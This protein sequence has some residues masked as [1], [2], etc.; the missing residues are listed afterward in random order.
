[1]GTTR[2]NVLKYAAGNQEDN[3]CRL[4][5]AKAFKLRTIF[6]YGDDPDNDL[7]RK[8]MTLALV[9]L[10]HKLEPDCCICY[11]CI[12]QLEDFSKFQQQ[13]VEFN[14][15]LYRTRGQGEPPPLPEV[16]SDSQLQSVSSSNSVSKSGR[17]TRGKGRKDVDPFGSSQDTGSGG[18]R[19]SKAPKRYSPTVKKSA[20]GRK[21]GRKVVKPQP[22]SSLE[23][24][25]S[26]SADDYIPLAKRKLKASLTK[27]KS[28]VSPA[29]PKRSR[30]A[31]NVSI[32]QSDHEI[33]QT[34]HGRVLTSTNF[35]VYNAGHGSINIVAGGY[36]YYKYR[37]YRTGSEVRYG[38]QCIEAGCPSQLYTSSFTT[39]TI[40]WRDRFYEHN[41]P[42]DN[43]EQLMAAKEEDMSPEE[44]E[45]EANN[46][47]ELV[48]SGRGRHTYKLMKFS[49]GREILM[50]GE[51]RHRLLSERSDGIKIFGCSTASCQTI[52]YM[53]K[54]NEIRVY[55]GSFTSTEEAADQAY[56]KTAKILRYEGH[57]F[58][59][60][61]RKL[62][63]KN[64][65]AWNCVMRKS[66]ECL[67]VIYCTKDDTIITLRN[68]IKYS[69]NHPADA[70]KLEDGMHIVDVQKESFP[71][72]STDYHI[73]KNTQKTDFVIFEGL[74]YCIVNTK[75]DG[76]KTCRC[77]E[78]ENCGGF[79]FLQS[80]G[81]IIKYNNFN[82]HSHPIPDPPKSIYEF[83]Y[84]I[85]TLDVSS[86]SNNGDRS[87][88]RWYKDYEY[89]LSPQKEPGFFYYRCVE[90]HTG[91]LASFITN[92][93]FTNI[94]ETN[95]HH[96]HASP[97]VEKEQRKRMITVEG[98]KDFTMTAN[99]EGHE[100]LK[101]QGNRY[102][103][104]YNHKEGWRVW[105]CFGG[106]RCRA[107]LFQ[108]REDGK[109]N[110]VERYAHAHLKGWPQHVNDHESS[111]VKRKE[112]DEGSDSRESGDWF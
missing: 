90:R 105:R 111:S 1:M 53:G 42:S 74:R 36:R 61:G 35:I 59:Y 65:T 82:E 16:V 44:H 55:C 68:Q 6:P 51:H 12:T 71:V 103:H 93:D 15:L 25:A 56:R 99:S 112:R 110:D 3:Y 32:D 75:V 31:K 102:C 9:K 7:Y 86:R 92:E 97:Q 50:Y 40:Y 41:H 107:T 87:L 34:K 11:R 47:F 83:D 96:N 84:V 33:S 78:T 94:R 45:E 20:A 21:P 67:T 39:G 76:S 49:T 106:P 66:N 8:V 109:I 98:T 63:N 57:Y 29:K 52:I 24:D 108:N 89:T 14:R 48:A 54:D 100:I 60:S 17:P 22:E 19:R 95:E 80:N 85:E 81:T 26:D 69:H 79:I 38:W 27:R 62:E 23:E 30:R 28:V 104:F 13:C 77:L 64:C 4:C 10:D 72:E 101:Y 37:F 18:K 58:V 46:T 70:F 88:H 91:C 2:E 5:F 73:A 43:V